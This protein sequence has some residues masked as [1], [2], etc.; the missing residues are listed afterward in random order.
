M[1]KPS[2]CIEICKID[3][4]S[5]W[6]IGCGRTVQEIRTWSAIKPYSKNK[7]SGELQRRMDRISERK[8]SS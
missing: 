4:P 2:P 1:S 5:G 8:P 7:I 6:C 3:R